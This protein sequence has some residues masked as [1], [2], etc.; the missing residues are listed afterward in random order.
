MSHLPIPREV[1]DET[2]VSMRV[3]TGQNLALTEA[4][5]ITNTGLPI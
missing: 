5:L 2:M 3:L 1:T 4:I